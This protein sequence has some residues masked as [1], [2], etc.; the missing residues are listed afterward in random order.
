MFSMV[1]RFYF[2]SLSDGEAETLVQRI[3]DDGLPI[4]RECRGFRDFRL[5]VRPSDNE[6]MTVWLWDS[7]ADW[8]AA[9]E[10]LGPFIQENFAPH[11]AQ[12]PERLG[13]EIVQHFTDEVVMQGAAS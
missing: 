5:V 7:E 6:I 13:G 9:L 11:L 1:G 2:R 12:A 8:N 3:E 4:V 10:R